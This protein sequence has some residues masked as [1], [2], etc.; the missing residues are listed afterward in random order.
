MYVK[1]FEKLLKSSLWEESTATRCV[2]ITILLLKDQDGFSSYG[3]SR[4]LSRIACVTLEEAEQALKYL[5]SADADT[6]TPDHEGRRIEFTPG[7]CIVL[8]NDIYKKLNNVLSQR[9]LNQM[10]QSQHRH[11]L[12]KENL[13]NPVKNLRLTSTSTSKK[14]LIKN[15]SRKEKG[16]EEGKRKAAGDAVFSKSP[17]AKW[18]AF[19]AALAA[20][21]EAKARFYYDLFTEKE[22]LNPGKYRYARWDIAA[23]AWSRKNPDEWKTR[24]AKGVQLPSAQRI[25][26][27]IKANRWKLE[28]LPDGAHVERW[29][30]MF[31]REFGVTYD[32]ACPPVK[33]GDK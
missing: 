3:N 15:K 32:Q 6:T 25:T 23:Q 22:L 13:T 30:E 2:W 9:E 10:Y 11:K 7:G 29:N 33:K 12:R 27:F 24:T 20:W 17:L 28:G 5:S 31:M 16:S 4:G 14:I 18:P 1:L 21:P 26:A 19:R 8:N